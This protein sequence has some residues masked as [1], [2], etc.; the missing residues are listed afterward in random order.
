MRARI[1]HLLTRLLYRKCVVRDRPRSDLYY[2]LRY[3]TWAKFANYLRMR[4]DYHLMRTT[5]RSDPYVV[6]V[7][8]ISQCNLKCP[9]CPTGMGEIDRNATAMSAEALDAILAKCGRHAYYANLWIWGEPMLNR[10]LADLVAVCR[11]HNVGSEVSSHLSLPLSEERIDSLIASGLD[12]LIVSNDAANAA[13]YAKYRIGGSF[14]QVVRNLRAIVARK[15]A[16]GSRTPFVEWQVV[17]MRHNEGEIGDIVRLARDIGVDGVRVKPCRLDKTKHA[18][19]LG[20]VPAERVAQWAP[21]NPALVHLAT[22]EHPAYIDFHCRFLWGMVSVYADGAMAPCCDTTSQ[23][24]D[25]GN[26]FRQDFH[27]IWN[28]PA[29]VRARRVA[30]GLAEGPADE[31]TACGQCKIF[32]KPLAQAEG[33]VRERTA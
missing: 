13:T 2:A 17:P 28:G 29:Y 3:G 27:E 32:H 30:L 6:R 14:E 22:P 11:R 7:E 20:P 12:W 18:G 33:R 5:V 10:R 24:D 19:V 8:P 16:L 23:R 9:L 15:K 21:K 31:A 25:L 1:A 26:L 4:V